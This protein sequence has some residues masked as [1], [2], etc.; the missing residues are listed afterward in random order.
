M[1]WRP[2]GASRSRQAPRRGAG[3]RWACHALLGL[4][5]VHVGLPARSG[6]LG[7]RKAV[8][9][10]AKVHVEDAGQRMALMHMAAQLIG[11]RHVGPSGTRSNSSSIS[12]MLPSTMSGQ[13]N[14]RAEMAVRLIS[15][16]RA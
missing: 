16:I 9:E 3:A 7:R 2:E 11:Y 1:L 12:D 6:L 8:P 5:G 10:A 15:S 14:S 4:A 13:A